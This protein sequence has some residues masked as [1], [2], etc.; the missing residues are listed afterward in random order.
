MTPINQTI[1]NPRDYHRSISRESLRG[2]D[3][4]VTVSKELELKGDMPGF[5]LQFLG[6]SKARQGPL[7]KLRARAGGG[8]TG[9][10]APLFR[11]GLRKLS[12]SS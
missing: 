7:V 2:E 12:P 1:S 11:Q 6:A 3:K 4:P 5:I 8:K 9:I 10:N